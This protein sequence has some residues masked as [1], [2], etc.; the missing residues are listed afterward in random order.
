MYL[1]L[2]TNVK[3]TEL[4]NVSDSSGIPA[5]INIDRSVI[6]KDSGTIPGTSK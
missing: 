2:V 6:E 3:K 4:L 5:D 1:Q